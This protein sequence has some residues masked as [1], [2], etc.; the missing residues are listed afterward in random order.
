MN[1]DIINATDEQINNL[2]RKA[3]RASNNQQIAEAIIDELAASDCRQIGY[4]VVGA[5]E[6]EGRL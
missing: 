4:M 2:L 1:F 3:L 5:A 6:E